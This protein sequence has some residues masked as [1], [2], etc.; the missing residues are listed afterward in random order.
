MT[1]QGKPPPRPGTSSADPTP[2]AQPGAAA[3]EA[4]TD[5]VLTTFHLNGRFLE[6]ADALAAPAGLTAARWQVVGAVLRRPQTVAGI[7]RTMGLARQSV[8][9]IADLLVA[10]GFAEYVDN[11]AHKRARLLTP[12]ERTREAIPQ[13]SARQFEWAT[14]VVERID[15]DDL[16]RAV[17]VLHR[18]A[19]ALDSDAGVDEVTVSGPAVD[20][21]PMPARNPETGRVWSHP[22][23]HQ[24]PGRPGARWS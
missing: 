1:R 10:D 7:A 24:T 3:A 20:D 19:R 16:R 18:V 5:L 4:L 8:Q 13:I 21:G 23:G 22:A 6:I 12:T 2:E 14:G 9:R 17:E 11:P 15:A